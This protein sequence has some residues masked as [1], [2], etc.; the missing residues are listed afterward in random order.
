MV[1]DDSVRDLDSSAFHFDIFYSGS[2]ETRRNP[3][4]HNLV[5]SFFT[6]VRSRWTEYL[7]LYD[8][9]HSPVQRGRFTSSW[10]AVLFL[11]IKFFPVLYL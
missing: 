10:A 11:H 7:F 4:R 8:C 2:T 9:V 6:T 1:W 5:V 3:R